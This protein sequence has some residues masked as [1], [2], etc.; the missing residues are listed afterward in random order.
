MFRVSAQDK[1]GEAPLHLALR[2][3][4]LE[5]ARMLIERGAGVSVQ[6]EDGQGPL[7]LASRVGGLE[8]AHMLIKR[9]ASVSAQNRDG[10]TA[11]HAYFSGIGIH[12]SRSP[13]IEKSF[14]CLSSLVRIWQPGTRTAGTPIHLASQAGKL[15]VIQHS[16]DSGGSNLD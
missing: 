8:I 3:G 2:M 5:V 1:N 6:N 4:R 16:A 11:F 10:Q 9:S 15:E 13:V 12:I 14:A 7:H